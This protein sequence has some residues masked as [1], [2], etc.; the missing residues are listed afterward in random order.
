[1]RVSFRLLTLL[2][3]LLSGTAL[4]VSAAHESNNRLTFAPVAASPSP[5]AAGSGVI[6]YI[7]GTSGEEPGR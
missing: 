4:A 3:G 6:N 1:M 7:K 2:L 5:D